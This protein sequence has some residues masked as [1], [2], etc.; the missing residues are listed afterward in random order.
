MA[1]GLDA[2]PNVPKS[3]SVIFPAEGGADDTYCITVTLASLSLPDYTGSVGH[4]GTKLIDSTATAHFSGSSTPDNHSE[5]TSLAQQT[6]T[7]FYGWS[8]AS[9]EVQYLGPVPWTSDGM[10]DI[11]W[12]HANNRII[13]HVH[14]S[15]WDN[16]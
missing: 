7:D 1:N 15:E 11:E 5:L 14:R 3:V 16:G 8:L 10:H 2:T 6:A 13:T 9:L 4:P 12:S